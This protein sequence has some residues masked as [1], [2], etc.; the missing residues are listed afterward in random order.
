MAGKRSQKQ[1]QPKL[2]INRKS[3]S[4]IDELGTFNFNGKR[5]KGRIPVTEGLNVTFSKSTGKIVK[6][7]VNPYAGSEPT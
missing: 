3:I 1:K 5:L 7:L 2:R 4:L 6:A